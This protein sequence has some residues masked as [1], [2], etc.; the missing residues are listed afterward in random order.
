MMRK[1]NLQF[2]VL[3]FLIS[4]VASVPLVQAQL[5]T[6]KQI[7]QARKFAEEGDKF[8]KQKNYKMAA[9][10][11]DKA[12]ALVP[13]YPAVSFYKGYAHYNLEE[14]DLAL[15]AFNKALSQGYTPIEIYK[16]RWF[17][18]LK[19]KDYDSALADIQEVIKVQPNNGNLLITLGDIYSGK[20]MHREAIENYQKA[21]LMFPNNA[22]LQYAIAYSYAR[23][24]NSSQQG[25]YALN[26]IQKGTRYVGDS[27]FLVA[28]AFQ[29]EKKLPESAEAF[30]KAISAKPELTAAYTNL[31]QIY[32]TLNRFDD[33]ITVLKKGTEVNPTD[34]NLYISLSWLYSLMDRNIEAVGAGKKAIAYAPEQYMGYT[35]L[36]RAYMDLKQY[37]TAIQT[38]NNALKLNPGDGETNFYI[39]RSLSL[40]S[41]REVAKGYYE[42]AVVG[43]VEF[44]KNNPD[45]AD[46]YYLL[47]NSYLALEQKEKAVVAYKKCL[48]LSPRFAKVV[49]NLGYVYYLLGD[50]VNAKAQH[51]DLLKI[52]PVLAAKL[53][54]T[55]NGK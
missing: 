19:N 9:D 55:I 50:K 14:F 33:A 42:K 28:S 35:N 39:G 54:D 43:L 17:I 3:L 53:L 11:Y 51:S 44:V 24:G 10:R 16:V 41:K 30:E 45:Y 21:A 6:K 22:D 31:S 49:Y 47:G 46:G 23:T 8:F 27:W 40:Q 34:G 1:F 2:A 38:C 15:D 36:C 32:Q 26:A 4:F 52:D 48:E 13:N 18:Y 20:N 25:V 12:S 37:D 29:T 7:Q 5:P